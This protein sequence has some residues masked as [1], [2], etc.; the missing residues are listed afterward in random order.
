MKFSYDLVLSD[1]NKLLEHI[2]QCISEC[3]GN[4]FSYITTQ[5]EHIISKT[6]YDWYF[7]SGLHV[8]EIGFGTYDSIKNSLEMLKGRLEIA[9][10]HKV[11]QIEA[12]FDDIKPKII[13]EINNATTVINIAVAWLSDK[14][15]INAIINIAE[16]GVVIR[17]ILYKTDSNNE[18]IESLKSISNIVQYAVPSFGANGK[19]LMHNK[20]ATFDNSTVITGSYNWS[21]NAIENIE[22]IIIITD[23]TL[24]RSF[25]DKFTRLIV[26]FSEFKV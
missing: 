8:D 13:Q 3:N 7:C 9:L 10:N 4:S 20:F 19:S 11:F 1:I 26:Q 16:R 17:I 21:F 5:Y 12:I 24:A 22:N 18:T 23:E 14:D 6:P 25:S 15:I 2:E